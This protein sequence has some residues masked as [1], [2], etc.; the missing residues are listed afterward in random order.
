MSAMGGK[1]TLA[2]VMLGDLLRTEA[3]EAG[4]VVIED[5][6]FLRGG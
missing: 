4:G 5:V 3:Q 1:R 6:A 2:L